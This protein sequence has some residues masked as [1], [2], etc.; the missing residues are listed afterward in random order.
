[1]NYQ[2]FQ[3]YM[4]V[5]QKAATEIHWPVIDIPGIEAHDHGNRYGLQ[6]A[7]LVTSGLMAALEPDYYGNVEPRF[8]RSLKPRV[9]CRNGNY[10]S[11][12]TKMF[13]PAD[14]LQLSAE[15]HEFVQIFG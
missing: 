8:A 3:N 14:Q 11:Y 10:M 4:L 7:D 15:Q 5:L 9:Y 2:D 6:L 12:G 13:P 1:M